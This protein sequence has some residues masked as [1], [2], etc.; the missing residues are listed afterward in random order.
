MKRIFFSFLLL[1]FLQTVSAQGLRVVYE[2]ITNISAGID[3]SKKFEQIDNPEART[4]L[5]NDTKS[6]TVRTA[7]LLV[8]RGVSLYTKRASSKKE[9]PVSLENGKTKATLTTVSQDMGNSAVYKN[10]I[11]SVIVT[12]MDIGNKKYLLESPLVRKKNDWQITSEQTEILG[13]RCIKAVTTFGEAKKI[14]EWESK[15]Q[16]TVAWY[17]PDIPIDA[18]PEVYSGLPGLILK[19]DSG[20]GLHVYTAVSAEPLDPAAEIPKPENGEK[21]GAE[22]LLGI[23]VEHVAKYH[24]KRGQQGAKAITIQR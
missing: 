11:D 7:E 21:V 6:P 10:Y 20:D 18:G 2:E 8:N 1:L 23:A 16:K 3:I 4:I 19:L 24:G 5:E 14:G 17:C 13:Y 12:Q 15:P 9:E 22:E